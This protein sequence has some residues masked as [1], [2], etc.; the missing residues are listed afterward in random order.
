MTRFQIGFYLRQSLIF[1]I[2]GTSP[3][4]PSGSTSTTKSG[5]SGGHAADSGHPD[6]PDVPE[7]VPNSGSGEPVGENPVGVAGGNGEA[8]GPLPSNW[9]KAYT[10]KG[11]V[12]FIDHNSGTSHWLD[13]RLSR[14]QKKRP[15]D[16][17][18]NELPYGWERIDDPHYGTY[19]IDHVNRRTQ[20][21][22][23]V[24]VAKAANQSAGEP[25]SKASQALWNHYMF[26]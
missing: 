1:R 17:D 15:E 4:T 12:Y 2:A 20:Y 9:E 10:D 7:V 16:C 8:L 24:L 5:G 22:N 19:Y 26:V 13:P 6:S 3:E 14:V 11:E 21:E 23:P 25:E 18:E